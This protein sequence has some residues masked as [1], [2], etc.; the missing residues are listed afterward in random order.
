[1]NLFLQRV[2]YSQD[3]SFYYGYLAY[4]EGLYETALTEFKKVAD[5]SQFSESVPF[6][7]AQIYYKQERFEELLS[8]GTP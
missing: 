1:M 5:L 8:E 6:Y 4:N 7:I 3:A 2:P